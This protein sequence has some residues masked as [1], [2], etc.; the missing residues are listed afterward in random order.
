MYLLKKKKSF[1][2]SKYFIKLC[3][4]RDI[5]NIQLLS[6]YLWDAQWLLCLTVSVT[7][8]IGHAFSSPIFLTHWEPNIRILPSLMRWRSSSSATRVY[9]RYEQHVKMYFLCP[10]ICILYHFF[11][12]CNVYLVFYFDRPTC[13]NLFHRY[14]FSIATLSIVSLWVIVVWMMFVFLYNQLVK[15][16]AV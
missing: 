7:E 10:Y 2:L 5:I 9:L 14:L 8:G 3:S 16:F 13:K 1:L 6:L 4:V 11:S 15:A 12:H